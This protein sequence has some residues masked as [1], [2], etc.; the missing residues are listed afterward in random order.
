MATE[1]LQ[2][3]R[4]AVCASGLIYWG[5]VMIQAR[6]IRRRIGRSP[7]LRPRGVR[8]Q[9]LWFG[10]FLVILTWIGQPLLVGNAA[11][12]PGLAGLPGL[13][14]PVSLAVGLALVTLG[15][16]GTLWTYA[17]MGDTWR[18][19]INANEKTA[20]V[21][22]GPYRWVRHPIY[23]LQIVMLAGAALLLPTP[24]SFVALAMHYFCVHLKAGDEEKHLLTVHGAAYRDYVSRTGRLFPKLIRRRSAA[25][26]SALPGAL[27]GIDS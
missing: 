26:N 20:L 13:L 1:E 25:K 2:L 7:N 10:W 16:A 18:I 27:P 4:V 21:S 17:A 23:L 11:T 6:R 8:E 24:V 15:Y 3:R 14:H 9:A 12:K 5:G 19:G 22:R